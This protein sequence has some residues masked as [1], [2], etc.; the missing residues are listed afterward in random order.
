MG[1]LIYED[2]LGRIRKIPQGAN[3]CFL[4]G[5][6]A[7]EWRKADASNITYTSRESGALP[8]VSAALDH[9]LQVVS[10]VLTTISLLESESSRIDGQQNDVLTALRTEIA[11]LNRFFRETVTKTSRN[12]HVRTN[13]SIA[14]N[15]ALIIDVDRQTISLDLA[16]NGSFDDSRTGLEVT[17][18]Q[19][20]LEALAARQKE[21]VYIVSALQDTVS[22]LQV[23]IAKG[24]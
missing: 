24:E 3:G 8:N 18:V 1:K 23:A 5:G 19:L 2:D 17:S 9:L 6:K 10:N 21:L 7:F 4:V 15:S 12:S 14:S 22:G 11:T 16:A 13:V 20:A